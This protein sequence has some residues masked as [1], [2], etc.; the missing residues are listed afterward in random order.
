MSKYTGGKKI[1]N[2]NS[3]VRWT[4]Y[5][6]AP[7]GYSES[8][9]NFVKGLYLNDFFVSISSPPFKESIQLSPDMSE[10][11]DF[12]NSIDLEENFI[13]IQHIIPESLTI[14][15][16]AGYKIGRIFF[17]LDG[18]PENWSEKVKQ[19]DEIWVASEHV[20]KAFLNSKVKESK[21]KVIPECIDTTKYDR[22]IN[23][24]E[25]KGKK[26][27]AFLSIFDW[28]LQ[29][30]WDVLIESFASVFD[31][32]DDVCLLL[33]VFSSAGF[34]VEEIKRQVYG[35]M[36]K[37]MGLKK[38]EI[39]EII[40]I[41]DMLSSDDMV[42]LIKA[43]DVFV[44]PSRGEGWGRPYMEAMLMGKPVIGTRWGGHLDFMDDSN[45][46]LIDCRVEKVSPEGI[47]EVPNYTGLN[48]ANPSINSLRE[49]MRYSYNNYG[50]A[51]KKAELASRTIN[52][53]YNLD[54]VSRVVIDRLN[55]IKS[56]LNRPRKVAL[57]GE[58][59]SLRSLSLM[60]RE[61]M[62]K[63]GEDKNYDFAIKSDENFKEYYE[64]VFRNGSNSNGAPLN[65]VKNAFL[66][67]AVALVKKDVLKIMSY[68]E[69][70][71]VADDADFYICHKS[72]PSFSPPGSGY[73]MM[74]QPWE[75]GSLPVDWIHPFNNLID[76]VWVYSNFLK[77]TY[78]D[79]GVN[80]ENI[81]VIH[82]GVD[83]SVFNEKAGKL[84]L[85]TRKKFRFLFVG[86]SIAR[87]GIDNLLNAYINEFSADEDVC[88][89]I[90]DVM[91]GSIYKKLNISDE[92]ERVSKNK[93]YPE[94]LYIK[95]NYYNLN[96]IASLYNS[97]DC[98]VHPYKAEGF[99]LPVAEAMS[100]GLPVI[101]TSYGA[102]LDFCDNSN[103][104]LVNCNVEKF[105]Q[106][107]VGTVETIDY[108]FWAEV[109]VK[110]LRMKMRQVYENY[111]AALLK[112]KKGQKDIREKF[113]W[114]NTLTEIKNSFKKIEKKEIAR[115]AVTRTELSE[116][117]SYLSSG[118]DGEVFYRQAQRLIGDNN[119]KEG[120][121]FLEKTLE[122]NP[123][124]REA[125]KGLSL[126]YLK[127]RMNEKSLHL[128]YNYLKY[129]PGDD[130]I[131]NLAGAYLARIGELKLAEIFFQKVLEM[132]PENKSVINNLTTTRETL[133]KTRGGSKISTKY[134]YLLSILE[135]DK[136]SES[137]IS[138][139]MI[140]KDEENNL[141]KC[142]ESVRDVVSEII[143]VDT[144]STDNTVKIARS[145]GARVIEHKW[146]DDFSKARNESIKNA[147]S[148][149]ILFLDADEILD[150][151]SFLFLK[152][153][154]KSE[155][156]VAYYV[157]IVNIS[158]NVSEDQSSEHYSLR[159]FNNQKGFKFT[160]C[161]HEQLRL[162]DKGLKY[163]RVLSTVT[164]KHTG[165]ARSV[166]K[167]KNKNSRN[168]NLLKKAISSEPDN[169]FN[170]YNMGVYYYSNQKYEEAIKSF[171]TMI[172]KLDGKVTS[173]LPFAYS[174]ESSSLVSL[175][176]YRKAVEY[177]KRALEIA[178][179]LKDAL[180]NLANAQFYIGEYENAV[181]NFKK[182][183]EDEGEIF[184]GGTMDRG[185]RSWK[186]LNGIGVAY[187]KMKQYSRAALFLEKA[188][189][190]EKKSPMIVLNLILAYKNLERAD[191]IKK[192]LEGTGD[193]LFSV[194]QIQ[195]IVNQ[196]LYVG[197]NGE[198]VSLLENTI[199]LYRE[200]GLNTDCDDID[201]SL[202]KGNIAEVL[203]AG[204]RYEEALNWYEKYL[205][206]YREDGEALKKYG[207][208][209]YIMGNNE[210]AQKAFEDSL[211]F[212][213]EDWELYNN[214]GL[215][216]MKLG[217]YDEAVAY[218]KK[219]IDLN[220]YYLESYLNM[221]K[222]YILTREYS[223]ASLILEKAIALDEK[224]AIPDLLF[225][226]SEALFHQGEYTRAIDN[227]LLY[228][229]IDNQ[230][231]AAFNRLGLCLYKIGKYN[232]AAG[233]FSQA[234]ELDNKK[235]VYFVNLGNALRATEKY[236]DAKMAFRCALLL[237]AK[238]PA[239]RM[240]YDSIVV[241]ESLG[242]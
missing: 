115:L 186:S 194:T 56:K 125:L 81:S 120:K 129:N 117:S 209:N 66:E 83:S 73:W 20:K 137:T 176:R 105:N 147:S 229:E 181:A 188:Y 184:L 99:G 179:D 122:T 190:L 52:K 233:F 195:H 174:F 142:L 96:E 149:W 61:I 217:S 216:K 178:P 49:L 113:S 201:I 38:E 123:F 221:G 239:A 177:A 196:L 89:V 156:P 29:K 242:R 167:H 241:K 210:K 1:N 214:L 182:A 85:K 5:F 93:K 170:Y 18:I 15:N 215:V 98:L 107:K 97:C 240:G 175:K 212:D 77:N 11:I 19:L 51:L 189:G 58:F 232:E 91:A 59:L 224:N 128:L 166:M 165:Y 219:S 44:L 9:R 185:A 223:E 71:D 150:K 65:S 42:R 155:E 87:K 206:L 106:K 127:K 112:A 35:Y 230:N 3:S 227:L 92:L 144:G 33:K 200:K 34:P 55:Q 37:K 133:K 48:W 198:A 160:G 213:E 153:L 8:A 205:S 103:A 163:S 86:G 72:P 161:I 141:K 211:A 32:R 88:L 7:S 172:E 79:S 108:P 114:E 50:E 53:R 17:E 36:T 197:L 222:A 24:L 136:S 169:A 134:R 140:V 187:L 21:I 132:N 13:D 145:H 62:L 118:K 237:D 14:D 235:P 220:P 46:F 135:E 41:E 152:S 64:S 238:D 143:V 164:V 148:D 23:P 25:I 234:T 39:P 146:E 173:Y 94:V 70:K 157:K 109:D 121:K 116:R 159:L 119:I 208:A 78:I 225:V 60:N 63:I 40:F 203:F 191:K 76:Q 6:Y 228:T 154:K 22:N 28:R 68:A 2:E 202:I 204:E 90:K 111:D 95:E 69:K 168:Y 236:E 110:D 162:T 139:C 192:L 180:Y 102:C 193:L 171:D 12:S 75:F 101:V 31:A 84:N 57:E 158:D 124:H 226:N 138:L 82:P 183:F 131:L 43:C 80:P 104:Y 218:F 27:F 16:R 130:E 67:N 207:I 100:C 30:G 74:M 26:K 47:I 151:S 45:S 231:A 10:I 4:A 199:N 54:T 126:Y